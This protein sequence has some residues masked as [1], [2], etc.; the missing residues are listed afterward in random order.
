[1][2]EIELHPGRPFCTAETL[3]RI[4]Q[5]Q[6]LCLAIAQ[7]AVFDEICRAV[8]LAQAIERKL[9]DAFRHQEDLQGDAEVERFLT[10]KGW[11]PEDLL[12]RVHKLQWKTSRSG[13]LLD[14]PI[15][16]EMCTWI[17]LCVKEKKGAKSFVQFSV[18]IMRE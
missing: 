16:E 6:G 3:N 14:A 5:Q 2:T 11:Q 15:A 8:P 10:A 12:L 7:A 4:A 9:V 17:Q 18:S 1:M 13:L